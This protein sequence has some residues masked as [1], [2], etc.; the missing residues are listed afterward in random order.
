[1]QNFPRL[2]DRRQRIE[3]RVRDRHHTDV[4]INGAERVVFRLNTRLCEGIEQGG[5]AD[6]GQSNDAAFDAH[7]FSIKPL[8]GVTKNRKPSQE[9]ACWQIV[10]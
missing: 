5:L 1:M 4:G 2:D 8:T 6:V 10:I 3:A 7:V 9:P